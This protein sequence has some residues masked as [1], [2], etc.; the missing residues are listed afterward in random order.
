MTDKKINL[1]EIYIE[2]IGE[3]W[4]YC[5]ERIQ[6]SDDKTA[7]DILGILSKKFDEIIK[8]ELNDK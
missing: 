3:V 4:N 5:M 6:Y 7:R 2:I 8:G 1:R